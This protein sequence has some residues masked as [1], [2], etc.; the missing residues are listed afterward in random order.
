MSIEAELAQVD[1]HWQAGEISVALIALKNAVAAKLEEPNIRRRLAEMYL[2]LGNPAAAQ[3]EIEKATKS[4]LDARSAEILN[5]RL[6]L[7]R[8]QAG[9]ALAKFE[10][11]A[12]VVCDS[13]FK[14]LHAEILGVA[15]KLGPARALLGDALADPQPDA[16]AFQGLAG[17]L[18]MRE[19]F[20]TKRSLKTVS[21]GTTICSMP[22]CASGKKTS[23][24][25][26][27][28]GTRPDS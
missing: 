6:A 16:A 21:I 22:T 4:G 13:E 2:R 10:T 12:S 3:A 19:S 17:I 9:V 5:I 8:N 1:K 15:G 18:I 14:A 26:G 25:R 28:L 7:L 11:D 27:N 20:S 23:M 24:A